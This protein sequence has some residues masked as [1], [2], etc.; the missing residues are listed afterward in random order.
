M[1]TSQHISE[2]PIRERVRG[3][4]LSGTDLEWLYGQGFFSERIEGPQHIL[5][6]DYPS[7]VF[8]TGELSPL[9]VGLERR[10]HLI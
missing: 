8:G 4:G 10:V 3:I 9:P 2:L 6:R 5:R 1:M 7:N